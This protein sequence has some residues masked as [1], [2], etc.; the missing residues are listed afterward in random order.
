[1][2]KRD[3]QKDECIQ[4]KNINYQSMLQKK[5]T[6]I[7]SGKMVTDNIDEYLIQEQRDGHKQKA[8][9]KLEKGI[10]LKRL[11]KFIEILTKKFSLTEK[12][13]LE[14]KKYMKTSLERKKLQRIKDVTYDSMNNIIKEIPGLTFN[15]TNRKFILRKIDK[16]G[17]TIKCLAP[18]NSTKRKSKRRKKSD[19]RKTERKK[20]KTKNKTK[21][22]TKNTKNT[23]N[24]KIENI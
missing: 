22:N 10:K 23:K 16:K 18:K 9:S 4:L 14:L 1:M 13:V 5:N 6:P 12:E 20:K 3:K 2:P 15:E 11:Y 17:T 7:D 8:W 21:N 19:K 24:N